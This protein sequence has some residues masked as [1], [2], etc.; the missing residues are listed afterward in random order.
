MGY[1]GCVRAE[2]AYSG[3]SLSSLPLEAGKSPTEVPRGRQLPVALPSVVRGRSVV[4]EFAL[5]YGALDIDA[6]STGVSR[7]D[8]DDDG[9]RQMLRTTALALTNRKCAV[10]G[11]FSER[12]CALLAA[13][14]PGH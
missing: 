11:L 6:G 1:T 9:H 8:Y 2:P 5:R 14:S 4:S 12:K 7:L 13:R 3:T 10:L